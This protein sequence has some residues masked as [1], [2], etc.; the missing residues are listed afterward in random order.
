M[1][2]Y[3][4]HTGCSMGAKNAGRIDD[5]S[6]QMHNQFFIINPNRREANGNKQTNMSQG[7]Y[8]YTGPNTPLRLR[9]EIKAEKRDRDHGTF[10]R[11]GLRRRHIKN[12]VSKF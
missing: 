3:F 11:N 2:F 9:S 12:K 7:I 1:L 10:N 4:W 8:I 5:N 6:N